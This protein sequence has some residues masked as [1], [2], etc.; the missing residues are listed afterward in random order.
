M[1]LKDHYSYEQVFN[2]H[3]I[4]IVLAAFFLSLTTCPPAADRSIAA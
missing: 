3:S 4:Q 1:L 2:H